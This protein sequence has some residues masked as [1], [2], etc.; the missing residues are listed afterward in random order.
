M[1][2]KSSKNFFETAIKLTYNF[3][4]L[5]FVELWKTEKLQ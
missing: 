2:L 3:S 5:G 1:I 4:E